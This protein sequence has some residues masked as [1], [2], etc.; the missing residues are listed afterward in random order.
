MGII[1]RKIEDE[2]WLYG[3]DIK[4]VH[5]KPDENHTGSK[6]YFKF[7]KLCEMYEFEQD[8]E[9]YGYNCYRDFEKVGDY[10][11]LKELKNWTK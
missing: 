5:D 1:V 9:Y 6:T 3:I 11:K 10:Y 8:K 7:G 2:Y 4:H